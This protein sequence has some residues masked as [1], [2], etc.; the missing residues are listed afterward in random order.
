MTPSRRSNSFTFAF[1]YRPDP[2]ELLQT[3]D[4][5]RLEH[6][7]PIKYG[8][9]LASPFTFLRGSAVLMAA[10]RLTGADSSPCLFQPTG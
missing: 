2:L 9:I 3:Q 5:G 4:E 7:L 6:L 10:D 8:R 1:G